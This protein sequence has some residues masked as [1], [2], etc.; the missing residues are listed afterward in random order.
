MVRLAV[1]GEF[2]A[3]N[4]RYFAAPDPDALWHF[5]VN[6]T[7]TAPPNISLNFTRLRSDEITAGM[8]EAG[9]RSTRPPARRATRACS[10]RSPTRCRTCGCSAGNGAWPPPPRCTELAT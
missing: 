4:F 7:I 6:D 5:F 1:F 3:I 10:R 9:R 8:N 2:D